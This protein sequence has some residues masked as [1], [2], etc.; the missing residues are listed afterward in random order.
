MRFVVCAA[1]RDDEAGEAEG[2]VGGDDVEGGDAAE[3][4]SPA[5]VLHDAV[6]CVAEHG[7]GRRCVCSRK[8]MYVGRRGD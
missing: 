6:V 5:A 7:A 4:V 2:E 1:G 8:T 3:A